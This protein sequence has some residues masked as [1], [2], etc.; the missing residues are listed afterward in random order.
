MK[1]RNIPAK[2]KMMIILIFA[3]IFHAWLK[4]FENEILKIFSLF[5]LGYMVMKTLPYQAD[6]E[7]AIYPLLI[8]LNVL[9]CILPIPLQ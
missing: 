5:C 8:S 4:K 3:G 6:P 2:I 7:T 9:K 1:A